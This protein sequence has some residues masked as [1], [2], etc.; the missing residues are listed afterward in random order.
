VTRWVIGIA[1]A[2]VLAL[3]A[4]LAAFVAFFVTLLQD[5]DLEGPRP[6]PA[7][8]DATVLDAVR[9]D[10]AHH[11]RRFS[12]T[13]A[14]FR[15]H[16]HDMRIGRTARWAIGLSAAAFVGLVAASTLLVAVAAAFDPAMDQPVEADLSA[17]AAATV[18]EADTFDDGG[19]TLDVTFTTDTGE[20]VVTWV[21][22]PADLVEPE[23]GDEVDVAYDPDDP[24]GALLAADID[25]GLVP[26]EEP[27]G[28]RTVTGMLLTSGGAAVLALAVAG[29]TVIWARRA[30]RPHLVPYPTPPFGGYPRP[31]PYPYPPIPYPPAPPPAPEPPPAP[32]DGPPPGGWSRP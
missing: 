18:L 5:A 30:P 11:G 25:Y 4:P 27:Y 13:W 10:G 3:P 14:A 23:P 21:Y 32:L 26:A 19:T 9:V 8:A 2:V 22:W 31:L 15:C 28:G 12:R 20:R 17:Q 16:D 6:L 29:A 1:S 7:R 24:E